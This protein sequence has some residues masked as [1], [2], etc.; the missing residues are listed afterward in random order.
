MDAQIYKAKNIKLLLLDVDGVLTDGRLFFDQN[1]DE[2][3]CF[4]A[5]D[6]LGIKALQSSGVAVGVM[7]GRVSKAVRLRMQQLDVE[8]IYQGC[9]DKNIAYGKIKKQLQLSDSQIAY[10]GDDLI[11]LAIMQQVGM[12]VAVQDAASVCQD[13]AD[14]TT[15]TPGGLG[16]V[17]EVCD[18][19]MQSQGNFAKVLEGYL[20]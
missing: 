9:T 7:S 4:H 11:D 2:Y 12:A 3:K 6:G 10:V 13:Y 14:W 5:R 17:R 1:G 20:L 19:I 18:F 8:H 16:A 15:A